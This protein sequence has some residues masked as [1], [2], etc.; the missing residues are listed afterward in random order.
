GGDTSTSTGPFIPIA[1][2]FIS[3]Q[4]EGLLTGTPSYFVRTSGCN[5]RCHFCDTPYTSWNAESAKTSVDW[6]VDAVVRSGIKHVV[7]TGGEPTLHAN[8]Q[9]LVRQLRSNGKHVTVETA[10]TCDNPISCDLL[11]LSPKLTSSA[12]DKLK[13]PGWNKRHHDLRLN[14]AIMRRMIGQ[15]PQTPPTLVVSSED[16]LD[17]VRF[18]AKELNLASHDI[19]LMPEGIQS[20]KI[21]KAA[22]WLKPICDLN[23]YRY[24][25]RMHI[26]WYGNKRGT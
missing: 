6:I 4:G 5:L 10:G 9:T 3:R 14:F 19:W 22:E 24:C 17:E 21:R 26:H 13:H 18:I 7:L 1:E 25:D 12:P 2:T 15:A 23:G 20:E 8:S 16:E 11:S